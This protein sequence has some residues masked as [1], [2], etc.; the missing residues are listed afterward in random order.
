[1]SWILKLEQVMQSVQRR[2]SDCLCPLAG[3]SLSCFSVQRP[4]PQ[5]WLCAASL[6]WGRCWENSAVSQPDLSNLQEFPELTGTIDHLCAG[7]D[8]SSETGLMFDLVLFSVWVLLLCLFSLFC[9]V[10]LMPLHRHTCTPPQGFL[11]FHLCSC[12]DKSFISVKK[13]SKNYLFRMF[14][15][16]RLAKTQRSHYFSI[17]ILLKIWPSEE[18]LMDFGCNRYLRSAYY[19]LQ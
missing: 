3:V 2:L 17:F 11:H 7:A 19:V 8:R 13:H 12:Q 6:E 15:I 10:P 4:P 5:S 16:F 14:H 9:F 1:M 18:G